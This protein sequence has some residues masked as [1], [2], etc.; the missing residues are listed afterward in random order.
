MPSWPL[1]HWSCKVLDRWNLKKKSMG[2][3]AKMKTLRG[4]QGGLTWRQELAVREGDEVIAVGG[5]TLNFLN[6]ES[7][8]FLHRLRP[9]FVSL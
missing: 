2:E 4:S 8:L 3:E 6:P 1:S 5:D 9:L 7:C